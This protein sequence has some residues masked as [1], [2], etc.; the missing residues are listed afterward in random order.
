MLRGR[1]RNGKERMK[2]GRKRNRNRR[3]YRKWL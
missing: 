2:R 1:L 3:R